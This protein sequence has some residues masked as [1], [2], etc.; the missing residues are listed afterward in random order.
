MASSLSGRRNCRS[1]ALKALNDVHGFDLSEDD[2]RCS[3]IGT[4]GEG[5]TAIVTSGARG[6]KLDATALAYELNN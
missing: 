1:V 3:V 5:D 6:R 4:R 2:P